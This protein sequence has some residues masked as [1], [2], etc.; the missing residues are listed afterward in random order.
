MSDENPYRSPS[1]DL[2]PEQQ[3]PDALATRWQR[4]GGAIIDDIVALLF[5]GPFMYFTGYWKL[6]EEGSLT[7]TDSLLIAVL[8]LVVFL[9]FHGYLLA[10]R[11]QTIGKYLLRTRIV[12]HAD[13]RI[14]PFGRLVS[15]RYV[16]ITVA[17]QIPFIGQFLALVDALWIFRADKRCVHDLIAGT[18]VV[19]IAA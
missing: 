16:P 13:N 6:A 1:A 5:W 12:S 8:G 17:N 18:K 14:L 4:L 11:G 10:Y 19:R 2:V 9:L 7:T 3:V 15:L